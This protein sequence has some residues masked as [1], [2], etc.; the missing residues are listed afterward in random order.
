MPRR[1]AR[2][3]DHAVLEEMRRLAIR[4]IEAGERQT[5]VADSME[6]DRR[7]V[8]KWIRAYR[9][10]GAAAL[11]SRQAPGR[12]PSLNEKQV[13]RLRRIILGKNPRQLNFGSPFWTLA[14]VGA[15]IQDLFGVHLHRSSVGRVLDRMGLTPQ[16]P[17][18]RAFQRDEEAIARW[19]A[20]D[21]PAIVREVRRKQAVLLFLDETGVE[22]NQPLPRTWAER[23]HTP[24]ARV[25][26]NRRKVSVISA[27]TPRGRL[28]FRCYRKNLNAELFIEFLADIQKEF[29]K[30]IVLV[31]DKHPAH[32]AAATQRYLKTVR[33]RV[34]VHFLPSY[35]P[36]LNPDEHVWSYLKWMLR[37][38]PLREEEQIDDVVNENM[39]SMQAVPAFLRRFF[40]DPNVKYIKDA[41]GW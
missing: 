13:A 11:A 17:V 35:A 33:R 21:F 10:G 37:S 26:G 32:V 6:V 3:L 30:K 41:L 2:T 39:R 4:R 36:E 27:L 29:S 23:G 12:P 40:R 15:V 16:V 31:I 14:V 25:S 24:I 18:A 28:W 20:E 7:T 38:E 9:D 19:M 1:D 34:S 5:A 8:R 22:E